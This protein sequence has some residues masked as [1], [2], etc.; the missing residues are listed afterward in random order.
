MSNPIFTQVIASNCTL[1]FGMVYIG[2]AGT[3]PVSNP[4]SV[5]S[6]STFTTSVSTPR[7]LDFDGMPLDDDGN[8]INLYANF[9]YT[10]HIR[11]AYDANF[12][13]DIPEFTL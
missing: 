4:V 6:D 3:D 2:V 13:Q 10:K 11:D 12:Y 1:S 8:R 9:N 7:P 5:F